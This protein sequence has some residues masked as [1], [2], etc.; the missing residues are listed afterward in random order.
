MLQ[1]VYFNK[2]HISHKHILEKCL[3]YIDFE[4]FLSLL[5]M[6]KSIPLISNCITIGKIRYLLNICAAEEGKQLIL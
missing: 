5:G 2:N 6:Y 3:L 1:V 4:T